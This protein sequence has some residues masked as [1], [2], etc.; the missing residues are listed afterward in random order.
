MA[1]M[2]RKYFKY[3]PPN[4]F[5][6]LFAFFLDRKQIPYGKKR[7]CATRSFRFL[8]P[9]KGRSF[10]IKNCLSLPSQPHMFFDWQA[11]SI[12]GLFY[13]NVEITGDMSLI[14]YYRD[15]GLFYPILK[16]NQ[17]KV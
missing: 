2:G 9:N 13:T 7:K 5:S 3:E 6:H 8:R 4:I 14:K 1:W 17:L 10:L 12:A 16:Y 11:Y 15:P